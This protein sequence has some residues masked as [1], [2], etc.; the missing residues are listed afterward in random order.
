MKKYLLGLMALGLLLIPIASN[1]DTMTLRDCYKNNG[2]KWEKLSTRAVRAAEFGIWKYRGTADQNI[3][4]SNQLCSNLLG[5]SVAS[6]YQ[7]SLRQSM[8]AAL[9]YIPVTSLALRD[10]T[11]L[12]M[13]PL[14]ERVFLTIDPG[15][16]KEEIVMCETINSISLKFETC[17][18]GLAFSGTST[19]AVAANAKTHNAGAIVVMSNVHYVYDQLVDKDTAETIN[20]LKTYVTRPQLSVD[21]DSAE[22]KDFVTF[23]QLSRQAIAGAANASTVVKGLVQ[24]GTGAQMGSSTPTG[25]TGAI[26][27]PN[28]TITTSSPYTAG[29]VI[30]VT[31]AD[32]KLSQSFT[33]LLDSYAWTGQHSFTATTTMATT[34]ITSSTINNLNVPSTSTSTLSK[35][36]VDQ[37]GNGAT[38]TIVNNL[39]VNGDFNFT[40]SDVGSG[41]KWEYLGS[42]TSAAGAFSKTQAGAKAA[43]IR[44]CQSSGGTDYYNMATTI[45]G[46]GA[47]SG[48]IQINAA[49]GGTGSMTYSWSGDALTGTGAGTCNGVLMTFYF[50][51]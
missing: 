34:T 3:K 41:V 16:E 28:S 15:R 21:G 27:V 25:S 44:F 38:T 6:G 12:S 32:G 36:N 9:D 7:K 50:Y 33:R 26:L 49:A 5:F 39:Q 4:L 2:W 14:G 17:T 31:Q 1:A 43:I 37:L 48:G 46:T 30:P 51:K 13:L 40:G 10:G 24:I 11:V 22:P 47:E 29:S 35:I 18:R 45:K 8:S 42:Q 19:V 23:G 20:G